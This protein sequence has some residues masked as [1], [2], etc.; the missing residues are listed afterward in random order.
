MTIIDQEE[1]LLKIAQRIRVMGF[2][3][4]NRAP[5]KGTALS[6]EGATVAVKIASA[7]TRSKWMVNIQRHG[8]LDERGIDAYLFVL[9]GVPGNDSMPLYLIMPAPVGRTTFQFS[10]S[11]L[12]KTYAGCVEDWPT[13]REICKGK[14]KRA[15]KIKSND[16]ISK[17]RHNAP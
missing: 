15:E 17:C 5:T 4:V 1:L 13:L 3:A 8:Q 16:F 6:I 14:L 11:S 7:S 2:H 10:F 12:V 9:L